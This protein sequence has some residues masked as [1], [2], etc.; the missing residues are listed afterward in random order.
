MT[1]Y[2]PALRFGWLTPI[3]DP[4]PRRIV[5]EITLKQRLIAQ[6]QLAAGQRAFDLTCITQLFDKSPALGYH[7]IWSC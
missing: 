4:A 2:I 3:Y 1:K 5:P 7:T 6:A